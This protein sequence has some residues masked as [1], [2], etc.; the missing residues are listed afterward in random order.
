MEHILV[1]RY[2]DKFVD[3]DTFEG[4]SSRAPWCYEQYRL[5][6]WGSYNSI[7][8]DRVFCH[9]QAPDVESFRKP[10]RQHRVPF[11][12]AWAAQIAAGL[13]PADLKG[14]REL[15]RRLCPKVFE[16]QPEAEPMPQ[17]VVIVTNGTVANDLPGRHL[18]TYQSRGTDR[19]VSIRDETSEVAVREAAPSGTEIWD[20]VVR[21]RH[22]SG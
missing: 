5:S 16:T 12:R 10:N 22:I 14:P 15:V 2:F 9:F 11:T 1:E 20:A 17:V 8:G 3:F 21:T 7:Q 4:L 19:T 6:Y 13:V 18:W